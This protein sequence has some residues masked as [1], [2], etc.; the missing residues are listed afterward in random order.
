MRKFWLDCLFATLFVF[1]VM[2]G[3][4]RITKLNIFTEFDPISKAL[5][6]FELTD[7]AFNGIRPDPD[8]VER[9]VMDRIVLVNIGEL[10]RGEFAQQLQI[11]NKYKP[12]VIGIDSYFDCEGGLYNAVDCPQLFLD[13]LGNLLLSNALLEAKNVVLVSKLLQTDSLTEVFESDTIEVENDTYDSMEVSDHMFRDSAYSAFANLPTGADYQ[14][15]IKIC[16]SVIPT[17]VVNGKEELAFSVRIAMIFDSTKTKK[18][19][20]RK[21]EEEVINF[22][23]NAEVEDVRLKSLKKLDLGTTDQSRKVSFATLDVVDVFEERFDPSLIK[24]NII[25]F[26]FLGKSLGD[27]AWNDKFFTPLN[28]KVGGRANPDMFGLVVHANIIAM[29]LS[30]KYINQSSLWGEILIAFVICFLNVALFSS[31][32]SRWPIFYDGVS[33]II[34]VIEIIICSLLVVFLFA[35]FNFKSTLGITM[36]ALAL[37]GPCFDM[38][39]GLVKTG[40]DKLKLGYYKLK[41]SWLTTKA[42]EV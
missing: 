41:E 2:G 16:K 10:S 34:Q 12:R 18:F 19:L 32:N 26:G 23:G 42:E 1:L 28:K 8:S 14:E 9:L 5:S 6:D 30:E 39:S 7:I 3:V 36:G 40:F 29:I 37:V 17:R 24:D 21:N 35:W 25:L 33:V 38:Y 15:G 27:P 20:K 22:V 11:I 4:Y 13:T 31:I